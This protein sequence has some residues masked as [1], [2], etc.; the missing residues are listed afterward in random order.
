MKFTVQTTGFRE[1]EQAMSQLESRYARR[2]SGRNALRVAAEPIKE[3]AR[4]F[5]PDDPATQ[6]PFDLTESIEHSTR[7]KSGP[8]RRYRRLPDH[9][10]EVHV[11]P[12]KEGY[13]QAIPQEMGTVHHAAHPFMRPAWDLEGGRKALGRISSALS[14]EIVGAVKKQERKLA[15]AARKAARNNT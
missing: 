14:D 8:Q 11:G 15:R 9:V 13:P 6:K 2:G 10:I 1:L 7:Q 3:R 12:T 4:S 5:A